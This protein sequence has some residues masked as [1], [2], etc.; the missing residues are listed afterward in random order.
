MSQYCRS[1]IL[2]ED[3]LG[4][5]RSPPP[6]RLAWETICDEVVCITTKG[7]SQKRWKALKQALE[8]ADLARLAMLLL[9]ERPCD[10][11]G[12]TCDLIDACFASHFCVI[13]KAQQERLRLI[14]ILEDDVYFDVEA[15]P[16]ALEACASFL[17]TGRPFSAFLFGGVYTEMQSTGVPDVY[18]GR[19][20]QAHAWLVNVEHP[21]WESAPDSG[22]RMQDV[23]NHECGET[24]MVYP[25]VAFQRD[26]AT[27]AAKQ[28]RPVYNLAE[29][30][31]MYR[32]LTRIG[33]KFGI[34]NCWEGCA[35]KT[36]AIVRYTGS[37]KAALVTL[38]VL[39]GILSIT[40]V[41]MACTWAA[42]ARRRR[43]V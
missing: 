40:V 9:N 7:A 1:L 21:V 15:L 22:F 18:H 37:I 16:R 12:Q 26:F 29:F 17:R 14:L 13:Q 42:R 41:S 32:A 34:Q 10:L 25:D 2:Y 35:R 5:T 6:R 38:G 19:G 30:P 23:Y 20:M 33:M 31:V 27:G 43:I 11:Q 24:Y 36:N 28:D 4:P 3:A 39:V 8:E